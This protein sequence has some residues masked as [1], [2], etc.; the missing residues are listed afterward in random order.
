M[1][2]DNIARVFETADQTSIETGMT[3]YDEAHTFARMLGG[4]KFHRAAGIIAALSPMSGWANNKRKAA[5][6]YRT[7]DATGLGL[8]R[9]ADKALRIYKGEDALDV[10]GGKKVRAFFATI[11]EPAGDHDPVI[12][13][14][15]FDIAVGRVTSDKERSTL[16]RKG[17]YERFAEAY[18][19]VAISNSIGA[20][21]LQAITW[22]SWRKTINV[23]EWR[24]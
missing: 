3:W 16:S 6:L 24:G 10:L 22:V 14:H 5:Q 4:N 21:Q 19:T 17:E 8:Y 9:N 1:L 20:A 13:R 7:G 18:R 11:V 15:A 2:T 12:D 23:G